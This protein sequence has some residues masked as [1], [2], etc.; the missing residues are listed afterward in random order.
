M[1]EMSLNLGIKHCILNWLNQN[2]ALILSEPVS[3]AKV[4]V[5]MNHGNSKKD[6]W[7]ELI[8]FSMLSIINLVQIRQHYTTWTG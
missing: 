8:F 7:A 1:D 5:K 2:L 3:V 4:P 6:K